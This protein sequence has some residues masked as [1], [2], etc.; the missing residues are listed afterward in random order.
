M[1]FERLLGTKEQPY[2]IDMVSWPNCDRLLYYLEKVAGIKVLT[3]SSWFLS[4]DY[5]AE[6]EYQGYKF[7]IETPLSTPWLSATGGCPRSIFE[8]LLCH[9]SSYS[10]FNLF[11]SS[12]GFFRYLK[13]PAFANKPKSADAKKRRG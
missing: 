1:K 6:F 7:E 5:F 11:I 9:V 4:G 3:K 2:T 8:E 10:T 13:L 12:I